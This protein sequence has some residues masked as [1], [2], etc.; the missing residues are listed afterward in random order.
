MMGAILLLHMK[1]LILAL[2]MFIPIVG[3]TNPFPVSKNAAT[4]SPELSGFIVQYGPGMGLGI[5]A[6]TGIFRIQAGYNKESK[7]AALPPCLISHLEDFVS[8]L[9]KENIDLGMA[10]ILGD[11]LSVKTP[12]QDIN[13]Y[14]SGNGTMNVRLNNTGLRLL[15][16]LLLKK[17][18]CG[19]IAPENFDTGIIKDI[20][21]SSDTAMITD[22]NSTR[23]LRY[24]ETILSDPGIAF[25]GTRKNEEEVW[26]DGNTE[27][28][29]L[30]QEYRVSGD[31]EYLTAF[32]SKHLI[33][34]KPPKP[35]KEEPRRVVRSGFW[36]VRWARQCWKDM[37]IPV[38]SG[39]MD[40]FAGM[41]Q[42]AQDD[43]A[44]IG[45]EGITSPKGRK[46][47]LDFLV[48]SFW[49]V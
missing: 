2:S 45:Y 44:I 37:D 9:P 30:Y 22:E 6:Q 10:L 23:S 21:I 4:I 46:A 16:E 3:W 38:V 36:D 1:T 11:Y 29:S 7:A 35:K 40:F 26:L 18:N 20:K 41:V 48:N 24:L 31:S 43:G 13:K 5:S 42:F 39:V 28:A 12:S 8:E 17:E 27:E 47:A 25:E 34:T 49:M 14:L 33:K 32:N 19:E 15:S